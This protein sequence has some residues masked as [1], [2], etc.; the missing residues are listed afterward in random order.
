MQS[1][2]S[3]IVLLGRLA[4]L[5]VIAGG[6]ALSAW[7][8]LDFPAGGEYLGTDFK[9][10]YFLES[11]LRYLASGGLLV[12]AAEVAARLGLQERASGEERN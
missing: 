4:G 1:D 3:A 7:Y 9:V 10:R 11:S 12:V 6:V 8:A 5:V 2:Q